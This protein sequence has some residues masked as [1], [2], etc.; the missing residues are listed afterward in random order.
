MKSGALDGHIGWHWGFPVVPGIRFMY[1][2]KHMTH[3]V[4]GPRSEEGLMV[5]SHHV[6]AFLGPCEGE[7]R[8]SR[9]FAVQGDIRVCIHCNRPGLYYQYW[10][11]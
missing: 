2:F 7:R 10:A 5:S 9:P 3:K 11:N 4:R 8:V 1:K 6:G